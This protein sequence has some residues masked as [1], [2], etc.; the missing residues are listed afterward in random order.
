MWTIPSVLISSI[1]LLVAYDNVRRCR[2]ECNL[3]LLGKAV[4][5]GFVSLTYLA[6]QFDYVNIYQARSLSRITWLAVGLTELVYRYIR[7]RWKV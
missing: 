4:S 3:L 6:I 5:W 2:L 1:A 7:V